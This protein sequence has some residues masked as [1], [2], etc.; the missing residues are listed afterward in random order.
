M[1][2]DQER[3]AMAHLLNTSIR[4]IHNTWSARKK[5]AALTRYLDA[6]ALTELGFPPAQP[7]FNLRD[8]FSTK[9]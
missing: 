8:W 4:R 7:K 2:A 5:F 1:Q 9:R 3:N 6:H